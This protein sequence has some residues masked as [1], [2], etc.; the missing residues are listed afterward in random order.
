MSYVYGRAAMKKVAEVK[1][2]FRINSSVREAHGP[3]EE[4]GEDINQD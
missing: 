2:N 1:L 4:D 3:G